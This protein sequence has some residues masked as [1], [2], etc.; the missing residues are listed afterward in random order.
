MKRFCLDPDI[1]NYGVTRLLSLS[2]IKTKVNFY[3]WNFLKSEYHGPLSYFR[4]LRL[5]LVM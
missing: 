5:F 3:S 4:T 1:K 2:G